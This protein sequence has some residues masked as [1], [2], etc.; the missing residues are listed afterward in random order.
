M[1]NTHAQINEFAVYVSAYKY[2]DVDIQK[3][4]YSACRLM[5]SYKHRQIQI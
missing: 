4:M 2:K 1:E 5:N 3:H